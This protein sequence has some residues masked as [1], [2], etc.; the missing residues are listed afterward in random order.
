MSY[1][2][3][4]G[5]IYFLHWTVAN[6]KAR[7]L[8][9]V[10]LFNKITIILNSWWAN[11]WHPKA[12]Q[13][14]RHF[15][16][17]PSVILFKFRTAIMQFLGS[18]WHCTS[19]KKKIRIRSTV[20]FKKGSKLGNHNQFKPQGGLQSSLQRKGYYIPISTALKMEVSISTSRIECQK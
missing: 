6:I 13:T 3:C 5:V 2:H 9:A 7:S 10:F 20:A 16:K 12:Q 15:K 19:V 11:T 18:V 14:K 17:N 1:K 8:V 4:W